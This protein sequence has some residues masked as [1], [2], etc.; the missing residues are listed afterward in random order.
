MNNLHLL[1][2]GNKSRIRYI[3]A[4]IVVFIVIQLFLLTNVGTKG[5]QLSEI[6]T[7]QNELKIE[8]E[9][10][11]AKIMELRSN[12]LVLEGLSTDVKLKQLEPKLLDPDELK[13]SAMD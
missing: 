6:R 1:S 13:I 10:L 12:K 2:I 3:I 7:R 5:K 9:I 8:N 4:L 11:K